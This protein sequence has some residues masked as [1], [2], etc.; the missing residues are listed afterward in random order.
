MGECFGDGM[1]SACPCGNSGG[2][3]RGCASSTIAT[4]ARLSGVGV[5][6][7]AADT[8]TLVCD[9]MT[10]PGLFFQSNG[11]LGPINFND[12]LLCAGVGI[13]RLGVVFPT[14]GTANYPGGLTP[15][16][17][18]LGGGPIFA[19]DVKHYQCWYR[20]A[21]VF[22]ATTGHNMSSGVAVTWTP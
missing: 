12:G 20:D 5:A 9:G 22:C 21:N 10:G 16:P 18:T 7:V 1:G 15:N 13:L 17:L 19:G 3:G 6:S 14:A 11:L 4:G 8:V 2:A